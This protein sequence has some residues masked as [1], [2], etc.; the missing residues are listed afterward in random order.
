MNAGSERGSA[1]FELVAFVASIGLLIVGAM[2]WLGT[3]LL[4]WF[5][6]MDRVVSGPF[7]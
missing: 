5:T 4:H 7:P 6:H 1:T 2:Y 3:V